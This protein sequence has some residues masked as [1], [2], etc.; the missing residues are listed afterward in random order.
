MGKKLH[1]ITSPD[2]K[3]IQIKGINTKVK[4]KKQTMKSQLRCETKVWI[5]RKV[6]Y[7]FNLEFSFCC[8]V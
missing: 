3:K 5:T 1:F 2:K 7:E 8:T 4:L 6:W